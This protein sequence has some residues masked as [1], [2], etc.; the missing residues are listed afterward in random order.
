MAPCSTCGDTLQIIRSKIASY[1]L[2]IGIRPNTLHGEFYDNL[3]IS[4]R[5]PV[6]DVHEDYFCMCGK[7][8]PHIHCLQCWT[9][10]MNQ[11][12]DSQ[13][14]IPEATPPTSVPKPLEWKALLIAIRN[15]MPKPIGCVPVST[16]CGCS[17]F[18]K[19]IILAQNPIVTFISNLEYGNFGLDLEECPHRAASRSTY[20]N[21]S[22][23]LPRSIAKGFVTD[24]TLGKELGMVH[25]QQIGP[26]LLCRNHPTPITIND[27]PNYAKLLI[28][29][30]YNS[31][32]KGYRT[33]IGDK[34]EITTP[35][36]AYYSQYGEDSTCHSICGSY[37][38]VIEYSYCRLVESGVLVWLLD[39]GTLDDHCCGECD[40]D[41]LVT[42]LANTIDIADRIRDS[43]TGEIF[44]MSVA[45]GRQ[46]DLS[47]EIYK[48]F[49]VHGAFG[50]CCKRSET[51][52]RVIRN[53]SVWTYSNPVY[54]THKWGQEEGVMKF[55]E[56][57]NNLFM[58]CA[59]SSQ[60]AESAVENQANVDEIVRLVSGIRLV[61][62][63]VCFCA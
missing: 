37:R 6:T 39:I 46:N 12:T 31:A 47:L 35:L 63:L 42:S 18:C 7:P 3:E 49:V 8:E 25:E 27:Q 9:G 55:A 5:H 51:F 29:N 57:V 53:L 61:D 26:R 23:V 11:H 22:N 24:S 2:P 13:R 52:Y 36:A 4:G 59:N 45:M 16:P 40:V 19:S 14:S 58:T 1:N 15:H 30:N 32:A 10:L 60:I 20:K 38:D 54:Y 56:A 17:S 21:N 43:L 44:N 33:R 41:L 34:I 50:F 62:F 48:A 28:K